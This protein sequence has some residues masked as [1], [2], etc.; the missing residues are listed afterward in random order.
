LFGL[1]RQAAMA[2]VGGLA[3]YGARQQKFKHQTLYEKRRLQSRGRSVHN[4]L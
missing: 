3:M 1:G 2:V 4:S